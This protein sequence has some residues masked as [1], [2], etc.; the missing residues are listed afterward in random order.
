MFFALLILPLFVKFG[1]EMTVQSNHVVGEQNLTGNNRIMTTHCVKWPWVGWPDST[2][3]LL[4]ATPPPSSSC[5]GPCI[6][7][8]MLGSVKL[9]WSIHKGLECM[10]LCCHT[11][12]P[13]SCSTGMVLFYPNL[14]F[15]LSWSF[16]VLCQLLLFFRVCSCFS[17]MDRHF[18]AFLS[19]SM[20]VG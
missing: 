7:V 15:S 16:M 10:E 6:W 2:K 19:P 20:K 4:S 1:V 5:V 12:C 3:D 17:A 11:P 13:S 18:V 8:Q 14:H 9:T